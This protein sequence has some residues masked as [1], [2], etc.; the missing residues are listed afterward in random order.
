MLKILGLN[1][2]APCRKACPDAICLRTNGFAVRS[3]YLLEGHIWLC[4]I[5]K[6]IFKR[7]STDVEL[8]HVPAQFELEIHAFRA[9]VRHHVFRLVHSHLLSF[10][11]IL[12]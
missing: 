6:V 11:G 1:E 4:A 2:Q 8:L 12:A 9:T 10:R 5:P 7:L 3:E